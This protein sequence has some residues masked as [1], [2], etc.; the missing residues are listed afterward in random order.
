[1][2]CVSLDEDKVEI[3]LAA[4]IRGPH[5]HEH[6]VPGLELRATTMGLILLHSL[7]LHLNARLD[8]A[9]KVL[10]EVE[11]DHWCAFDEL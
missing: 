5:I 2:N 3:A 7:L 1:M 8:H 10:T 9:E 6:S 11:E 4:S